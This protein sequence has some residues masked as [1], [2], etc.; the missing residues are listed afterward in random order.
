MMKYHFHIIIREMGTL[1]AEAIR[2]DIT[3]LDECKLTPVCF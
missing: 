3:N 1:T 2:N